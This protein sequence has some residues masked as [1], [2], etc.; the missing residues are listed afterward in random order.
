MGVTAGMLGAL[1]FF[2]YLLTVSSWGLS[3]NLY[4]DKLL[5]TNVFPQSVYDM[6][7][8]ILCVRAFSY[9]WVCFDC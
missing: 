9:S 7:K 6:R 8:V 5:G 1:V 4:A 2:E 3:Y